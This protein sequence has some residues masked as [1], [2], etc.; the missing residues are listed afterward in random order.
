MSAPVRRRPALIVLAVAAAA[1]C[2]ALGWW[3]WE[4]FGS[5]S[6][7][8]Q[9]LGYALQWPMFAAFF[10]YAYRKFV[11][12]EANPEPPPPPDKP[13]ELPEDLL[14][15]RPAPAGGAGDDPVLA[16]YNRYL[17]ELHTDPAGDSGPDTPQDRT[18]A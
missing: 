15:P 13:R 11:L 7:T 9:N 3:Q 8:F 17:A 14:P 18:T 4:R 1:A 2:L 16:E 10:I 5:S 6:G 12:L